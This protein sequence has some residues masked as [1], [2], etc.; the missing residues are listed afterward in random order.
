MDAIVYILYSC[1]LD[2]YYIGYT[3]D[4]ISERLRRR[5]SNHKGFTS[6]AKDWLLV[7]SEV[8]DTKA[9]AL[10]RERELKGWNS[11][12]RVRELIKKAE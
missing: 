11:R 5:L 2:K 10:K 3:T 9:E 1:E 4:S 6:R 12:D 7:Y 8:F